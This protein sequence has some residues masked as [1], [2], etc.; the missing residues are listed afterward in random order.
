MGDEA[1]PKSETSD[2]VLVH[3]TTDDGAG[4][5]VLRARD[6]QVQAG[7]VRPLVS[8]QPIHGDVIRIV[9][10]GPDSPLCDVE[11]VFSA[12]GVTSTGK[13]AMDESTPTGEPGGGRASLAAARANHQLSDST[14]GTSDARAR[15][16][17]ARVSSDAYRNNWDQLF[18]RSAIE[19]AA[20]PAANADSRAVPTRSSKLLN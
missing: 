12:T 4:L 6:G 18:G 19:R 17:P 15:K 9:P 1:Q 5:R 16:G 3:G 13:L 2:V 7:E 20:E 8:G 10:R 11:T 14:S